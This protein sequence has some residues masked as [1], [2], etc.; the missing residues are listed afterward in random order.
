MSIQL[1]QICLVAHSLNETISGLSKVLGIKSCFIDS[2]VKKWGLENNLI[3]IGNNFLEVVSPIQSGTA[4]GRYL[5][6]RQGDGGYMVI[7]QADNHQNQLAV[8]QRAQD[9]GVRIA[10]E[11]E[12]AHYHLMQLHPADMQAAFLEVDWD[13]NNDFDGNWEPAGG[14]TWTSYID[15][16]HTLD[17][18]GVELQCKD[19][20]ALTNKWAQVLGLTPDGSEIELHNARLRFVPL[21]DDRGPGMCGIDVVVRSRNSVMTAAKKHG[22]VYNESYVEICGVRFYLVDALATS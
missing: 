15:Q 14:S 1:R 5:Q 3:S 9:T 2:A 10:W 20:K 21:R 17:F 7:C 16:T 13:K 6:R 19:P 4:A 11:R 18:C 8:K 22:F 12:S